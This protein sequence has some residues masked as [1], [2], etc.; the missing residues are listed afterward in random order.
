MHAVTRNDKITVNVNLTDGL[1]T[2]L[3]NS[4]ELDLQVEITLGGNIIDKT[5]LSGTGPVYTGEFTVSY[6]G[7]LNMDTTAFLEGFGF[8]EGDTIALFS[9]NTI[10]P[11]NDL[12]N[13]APFLV[14]V[15][16]IS[17]MI[18]AVVWL[19]TKE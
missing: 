3:V 8:A 5:Q 12:S 6:F 17:I 1:G 9:Q 7:W 18:V 13:I 16:V 10:N 19:R 4:E 15:F 2:P 14:A 11:Y